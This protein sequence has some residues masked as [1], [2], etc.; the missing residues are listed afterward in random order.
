MEESKKFEVKKFTWGDVKDLDEIFKNIYAILRKNA[1][2]SKDK[3]GKDILEFDNEIEAGVAIMESLSPAQIEQV[4]RCGVKDGRDKDF[5][6]VSIEE[7][8]KLLDD[9]F[10]KNRPFFGNYMGMKTGLLNMIQK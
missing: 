8:K 5:S 3:E 9:I 6:S 1:K 2:V 10:E 7:M 4:I